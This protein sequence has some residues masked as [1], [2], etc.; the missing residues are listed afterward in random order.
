MI[1]DRIGN[2][3]VYSALGEGIA[4]GLTFISAT[5]LADKEVG[6]YEL[7]NG[8]KAIVAVYETKVA[9]NCVKEAHEKYIDIQYIID[10]EECI[11][12]TPLADKTPTKAYN[13]EKDVAF[14]EEEMTLV[15]MEK[16][17]FAIFYPEDI[18]MPGSQYNGAA[19][20]KKLVVKVPV[21]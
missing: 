11:G 5:N 15:K 17:M 20:V 19:S 4:Q 12:Y 18:H 7:P 6:V 2:K 9:L 3:A 14:Y 16:G 8:L 1:V 10:G 13:P 21:V